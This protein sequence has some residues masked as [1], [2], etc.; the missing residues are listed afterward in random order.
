LRGIAPDDLL[1]GL[2]EG[3]IKAVLKKHID[4]YNTRDVQFVYFVAI[5]FITTFVGAMFA[6]GNLKDCDSKSLQVRNL[7]IWISSFTLFCVGMRI[8]FFKIY[9][10]NP[11]IAIFQI[12]T[13][14]V[15]DKCMNLTFVAICLGLVAIYVAM[16]TYAINH[17]SIKAIIIM[18][19]LI[20]AGIFDTAWYKLIVR[21]INRLAKEKG[22]P[23]QVTNVQV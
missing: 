8:Y 1:D 7:V 23:L 11:V 21:R 9:T 3:P 15:Y 18:C 4:N 2:L 22:L 10:Q 17:E 13:S 12:D 20:G 5:S 19:I 16:F 14:D 6:F